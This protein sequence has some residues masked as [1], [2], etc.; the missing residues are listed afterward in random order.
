M[1]IY[2]RI[3]EA[4]S[5]KGYSINKLEKELELP[6]S[7]I[8]KYNKNVPS[9]ERIKKIADFLDVSVE[10]LTNDSD[11]SAPNGYYFNE[12]TAQMAQDLFEN[13]EL[14]ILFSAARDAK[15]EDLKTAADVLLA[16]KRKE[17]YNGDDPA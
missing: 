17:E 2:E 7:S 4:A 3:K 6:R 5:K 13:K 11:I 8:S 12:E 9:I 1:G 10:T 16:L 14:R 15:P